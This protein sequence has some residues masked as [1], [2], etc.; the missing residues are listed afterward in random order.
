MKDSLK[1]TGIIFLLLSPIILSFLYQ[2][3][4]IDTVNITVTDKERV[5]YS[6][7]KSTKSKYLIF[8]ESETFENVDAW[9]SG[10]FT[11]SDLYGKLNK[12]ESYTVKVYGWRIPFLSWY[13]NIVRIEK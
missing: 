2:Q 8:T 5:T 7:D 12:G 13:R 10:K 4:T 6:V 9:L 11:S 1:I 3:G